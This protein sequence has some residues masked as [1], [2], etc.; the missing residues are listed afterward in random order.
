[1]AKLQHE[2]KLHEAFGILFLTT[3]TL[4]NV[5]YTKIFCKFIALIK[6]S[7][8]SLKSWMFQ[9]NFNKIS[10]NTNCLHKK[11]H[12]LFSTNTRV[13]GSTQHVQ[14]RLLTEE[15][16]KT[17]F[18]RSTQDLVVWYLKKLVTVPRS[19]E[20]RSWRTRN[21]GFSEIQPKHRTGDLVHQLISKIGE[22]R[23]CTSTNF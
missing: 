14:T 9:F 19:Q 23:F 2:D 22:R 4:Q 7:K 15:N 11:K 5:F 12:N 8:S 21:T 1:M 6:N 17:W 3:E 16:N 13:Y 20:N 10:L 18:K